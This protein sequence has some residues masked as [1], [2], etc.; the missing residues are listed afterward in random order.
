[1]FSPHLLTWSQSLLSDGSS[2]NGFQVCPWPLGGDILKDIPLPTQ[3]PPLW[4]PSSRA[5]ADPGHTPWCSGAISFRLGGVSRV[6][7]PPSLIG[8]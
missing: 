2:A 5:W 8:S 1:M 4:S 3:V 7:L 6:R